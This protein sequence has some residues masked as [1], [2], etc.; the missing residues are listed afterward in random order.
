MSAL[1]EKRRLRYGLVGEPAWV[2]GLNGLGWRGDIMNVETQ[3][4]EL[5]LLNQTTPEELAE[6]FVELIKNNREIQRAILGV[7][8][9]CANVMREV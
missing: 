7:V 2:C 6:L 3:Q 9:R 5:I 1:N 8:W 4:S